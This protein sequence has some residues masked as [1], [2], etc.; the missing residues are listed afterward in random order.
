[1]ADVILR[2]AGVIGAIS[3]IIAAVVT[4]YK[5][6]RRIEK[7]LTGVMD[8]IADLQYERLAQAHDFYTDRG[9]CPASKKKQL[10]IIYQSYKAK[11]RNHLTEHYEENILSL[12]EEPIN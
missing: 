6:L 9:W 1:L 10:C 5:V 8:D 7:M 4:V 2:L 12:P 11:G 3:T